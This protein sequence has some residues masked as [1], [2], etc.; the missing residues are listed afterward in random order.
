[1]IYFMNVSKQIYSPCICRLLTPAYHVVTVTVFAALYPVC[2]IPGLYPRIT[3][4]HVLETLMSATSPEQH[5]TAPQ[6]EAYHQ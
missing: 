6:A 4:L 1:M 5:H 3:I 2:C